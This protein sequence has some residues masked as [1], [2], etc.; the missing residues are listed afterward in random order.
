MPERTRQ[1]TR[2]IV[3]PP[4][5]APRSG[6]RGFSLVE[7]LVVV[8]MLGL[9]AGA[10][11]L[12]IPPPRA[13]ALDEADALAAQ[14]LR[15]REEAILGGRAVEV[16]LDAGGYRFAVRGL[17]GREVLSGPPLG[18][19]AWPPGVQLRLHG[20]RERQVLR[21]DPTGTA[22]VATIELSGDGARARLTVDLAGAVDVHATAR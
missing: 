7:L 4:P 22:E 15:A 18:E 21:F 11:A 20:G 14:L 9:L 16:E 1:R 12:T 5:R 19:R 10:V 8:A 17:A 13:A 6:A 3:L 2:V